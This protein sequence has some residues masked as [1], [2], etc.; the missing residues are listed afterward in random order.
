M[1]AQI[2]N[3]GLLLCWL[4]CIPSSFVMAELREGPS[5]FKKSE[6]P[7]LGLLLSPFS[8][9]FPNE[10]IYNEIV[11]NPNLSPCISRGDILFPAHA[12]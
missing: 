2:A 3:K 6:H 10:K 12:N 4:T 11:Y 5:L 1:K 9:H 8:T 7:T